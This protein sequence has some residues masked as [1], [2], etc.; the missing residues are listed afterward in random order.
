MTLNCHPIL[1]LS[2]TDGEN[3]FLTYTLCTDTP[4]LYTTSIAYIDTPN[5]CTDT[6]IL[7]T[8]T[9]ILCTNT[10][11]VNCV[12]IPLY[13]ALF[14]LLYCVYVLLYCALIILYCVLIPLWCVLL[15]LQNEKKINKKK[16]NVE[17]KSNLEKNRHP[18]KFQ[19][20]F[21]KISRLFVSMEFQGILK[22]FLTEL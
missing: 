14:L 3:L 19:G 8:G 4:L 21:K 13:C 22:S 20:W 2:G 1:F 16:L 7:L 12:L 18:K 17:E 9:M 10:L 15:L 5:L 6:S 11:T